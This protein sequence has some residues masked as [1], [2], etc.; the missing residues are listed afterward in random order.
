M[1]HRIIAKLPLVG[2][3]VIRSASKH[4]TD[5]VISNKIDEILHDARNK[6]MTLYTDYLKNIC[7][8]IGLNGTIILLAT[9]HFLFFS[10]NTIIIIIVSVIS[11]FMIARFIY[12]TTRNIIKV[13][14]YF[15]KIKTFVKD[16]CFYKSIPAA[17][18]ERIR[19]EFW[20]RYY[21]N[22]NRAGRFAHSVAS[23]L[24]LVK[25]AENMQ[26]EVVD[27]FYQLIKYFLIKNII[28][29]AA[30]VSIFYVVFAFLLKPFVF[31][32]TMQMKVLDTIIY[33]FTVTLPKFIGIFRGNI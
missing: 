19:A 25:S 5:H 30:T 13:M 32:L 24:G 6:M 29:K 27:Q 2:V 16:V 10:V 18:K 23:N 12:L 17:V 26:D 3:L 9:A 22:T 8:F 14:P 20:D 4:I 33:P 15:N 31:S 28:Y 7:F 21:S 1:A 11:L